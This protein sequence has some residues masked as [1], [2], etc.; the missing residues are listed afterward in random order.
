MELCG[1]HAHELETV[2]FVISLSKRAKGCTLEGQSSEVNKI[3]RYK[4]HVQANIR[5]K[6][7]FIFL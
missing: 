3:I 4:M 2:S 6:G 5:D 1:N 7:N